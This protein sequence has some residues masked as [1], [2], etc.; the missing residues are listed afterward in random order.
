MTRTATVIKSTGSW[1]ILS[2]EQSGERVESRLKGNIRLKGIRSTNPVVVGDRVD[3]E[4]DAGGSSVISAVHERR[5]YIIR[6]SPNLSKESH[7]IAA[8]IDQAFLVATLTHPKTSCEFID[9]FL[10]TA[11]AYKIPAVIILNKAD[12]YTT[13]ELRAEREEFLETYAMAGYEVM[14]TAA[15]QNIGIDTLRTRLAGRTSLF[16]GNSG[17][18]KSTLI[19]AIDP[20]LEVRT[21]EVSKS[22]NKGQHTTTFSEMFPLSTGGYIIDTPGIKGFG[23]IDIDKEETA[24]YFP[25]LFRVSKECGYY[26]CTHTHE[27]SCAVKKAVEN[28]DIHQSRYISYLKLL[29]GDDK[30]R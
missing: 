16:S 22:H 19:N 25:D 2:D 21:G 3:Y 23:L 9:R 24:R 17:V 30:Y 4:T 28:G 20:S 11:E 18:G 7:I 8:N 5:N 12:I 6:R 29:E 13:E 27:P 10:V 15:T 1:Y 26:N 14:E